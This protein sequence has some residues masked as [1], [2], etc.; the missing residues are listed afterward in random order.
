MRIRWKHKLRSGALQFTIFISVIIALLLAGV[1]ILFSTH[2]FFLGQSKAAIDNIRLADSGIEYLCNQQTLSPDTITLEIPETTDAQSVKIHLTRWGIYEKAYVEATH[3]KKKFIKTALIGSRFLTE[4]RNSLYL[5]ETFKPLMVVGTTRI[6]GKASLPEQGVRT[7][8]ISGHS[9]YN[10]QLVYG[11]VERSAIKLPKL[12]Y[13][14]TDIVSYYLNEYKPINE[15]EYLALESGSKIIN[16]FINPAKGYLS[17]SVITLEDI[18]LTGNIIIQ[19]QE[20]IIVKNSAVLKDIIL[21]A[22][23]IEIEDNFQGSLQAFANETIKVGK[24]CRLEYPSSLILSEKEIQNPNAAFNA[25]QN[26][27]HIDVETKIKGSICYLQ[28]K[29]EPGFLTNIHIGLKSSVAGEVYC[30]GNLELRGN[31]KGS[32]YTNQ[33]I[34]NEG[35]TV[36]INHLY[37]VSITD[38][39]P[40]NFGGILFENE[41]KSVVKWLY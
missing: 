23:V 5:Q 11:P 13:N 29:P 30:E 27:I 14:Y 16:S 15:E 1:I 6:E 35:G 7:G 4:N 33:F 24:K 8:N 25:L 3:R 2:R 41:K 31:V 10:D 12:K 34:A 36:F 19:S 26:K 20:K 39:L 40:E 9:Y 17:S 37:N 38:G 32:V 22:P 18:S 28:S 21:A